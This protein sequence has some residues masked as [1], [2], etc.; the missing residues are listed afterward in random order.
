MGIKEFPEAS[1]TFLKDRGRDKNGKAERAQTIEREKMKMDGWVFA[2]L[3]VTYTH[4]AYTHR[5]I[6]L[7]NQPFF[8]D[9]IYDVNFRNTKRFFSPFGAKHFR[10]VYWQQIVTDSTKNAINIVT[11]D[12]LHLSPV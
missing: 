4:I 8:D 3:P 1:T 6:I 11:K 5:S 7:N 12:E 2:R 10:L 9:N